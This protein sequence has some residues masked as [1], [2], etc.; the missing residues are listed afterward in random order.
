LTEVRQVVRG[1]RQWET[2]LARAPIVTQLEVEGPQDLRL[3]GLEEMTSLRRITLWDGAPTDQLWR[4]AA[5]PRLEEV[6]VVLGAASADVAALADVRVR[7]LAVEAHRA[8]RALEASALPFGRMERLEHLKL[9]NLS[10]AVLPW[11]CEWLA[12]S[13]LE[14]LWV[15]GFHP[16]GPASRE[17]LRAARSLR[18]L[19]W[20]DDR[21][22]ADGTWVEELSRALPATEVRGLPWVSGTPEFA[23]RWDW[24]AAETDPAAQPVVVL[25]TRDRSQLA[26][27]FTDA[28]ALRRLLQRWVP[29]VAGRLTIDD[30]P[31]D[32]VRIAAGRGRD[33]MFLQDLLD[34]GTP[35]TPERSASDHALPAF[36]DPSV[37]GFVAAY[38]GDLRAGRFGEDPGAIADA[39][40]AGLTRLEAAGVEGLHDTAVREAF[41]AALQQPLAALGVD[42]EAVVLAH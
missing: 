35:D 31:G 5:L 4:L 36:G 2:A 7:S 19:W 25:G 13:A 30:G 32:T 37:A 3:D 15:S 38:L 18:S 14:E 29:D 33:L 21:G 27:T 26:S 34:L 42:A 1:R 23:E 11:D 20:H 40:V 28:A 9:H 10:D 22:E 8:R 41:F 39:W 6:H 17:A 16:A 24:G 12:S